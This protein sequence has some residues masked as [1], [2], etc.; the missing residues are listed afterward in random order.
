MDARKAS[1]VARAYAVLAKVVPTITVVSVVVLAIVVDLRA[2]A[3][4]TV[5]TEQQLSVIVVVTPTPP[6]P[7]P[8]PPPPVL[9][10]DPISVQ[11]TVAPAPT[12]G[13][14]T[15]IGIDCGAEGPND[16]SE[17]YVG[18]TESG[19]IVTLSAVPM[20]GFQFGAWN[21]CS[22]V[23]SA[24][25]C[26]M[27]MFGAKTISV[28][29]VPVVHALDVSLAG[30]GAGSVAST[31]HG[32]TCP[33]DCSESYTA[34]TAVILTATPAATVTVFPGTTNTF[35]GWSGC[36]SSSGVTCGVTMNTARSVT[37]TFDARHQLA[38]S[39]SGNGTV[40]GHGIAC[41]STGAGCVGDYLYG[42]SIT[43]IATP[44][45]G[46]EVAAWTGCGAVSGNQCTLTMNDPRS[47]SVSF[48]RAAGH[49]EGR[50][51]VELRCP[52]TA[53]AGSVVEVVAA[54]SNGT[55]TARRVTAS[56]VGVYAGGIN[57][58]GPVRIVPPITALVPAGSRETPSTMAHRAQVSVP[59]RALP[60]TMVSVG[61]AF[62][63]QVG[64]NPARRPLGE[65][66]CVVE[67][68]R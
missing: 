56:A 52:A 40:S 58:V 24:Q 36:D 37:A 19:A 66:R 10:P 59:R 64:A 45:A 22:A 33:T 15:A 18:T 57:L 31:A 67:V 21:G 50:F 23:N 11:L 32:I 38:V 60:R 1:I 30:S 17:V 20:A 63:G 25:Q 27:F 49:S 35:T 51:A 62:F 53:R 28:T 34:G 54:F 44:S 8:P 41:G 46:H 7:P 16:C 9:E 4:A 6:P 13:R 65:S 42:T 3:P 5:M 26:T 55:S 68:V 48:V 2:Q 14:V 29:F 61:M 43:L 47:V 12:G 39:A